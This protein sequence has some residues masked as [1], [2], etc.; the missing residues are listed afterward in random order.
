MKWR[1]LG[2]AVIS[3]VIA[4]AVFYF[5]RDVAEE[6]SYSETVI[7]WADIFSPSAIT[8]AERL[9]ELSWFSAAASDLR[10]VELDSV[11]EDIETHYWE[12]KILAKAFNELTGIQI[13]HHVIP[14]GVLVPQIKEQVETG[15]HYHDIYVNDADLIGWHLRS[16]GVVNLSDYMSGEGNRYTDPFLDLPDYL[17]IEFGQDYD[18]NILQLPDQQ[19]VNLYWFRYDWFV[20][21]DL[22]KSFKERFGYELGVPTNW[23]AYEDIA[24]FFTS[25]HVD[26]VKVYGHLDYGKPSPSLG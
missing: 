19:F 21:S 24:L 16:G 25:T 14:E 8:R 5:T 3:A 11:A 10:G 2:L 23:E 20:R 26:G 18:G 15:K 17:N 6:K 12:S 4:A 9:E 1:I 13:V 7:K 22:R